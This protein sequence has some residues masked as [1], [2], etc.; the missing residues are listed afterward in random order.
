[1][2]AV[3]A[4]EQLSWEGLP[5]PHQ[6][7]GPPT[8]PEPARLLPWPTMWVGMPRPGRGGAPEAGSPQVHPTTLSS[9]ALGTSP[10]WNLSP[11]HLPGETEAR[12][13]PQPGPG[14]QP[15]GPHYRPSAPSLR[16]CLGSEPGR[17]Q[18]EGAALPTAG[19]EWRLHREEGEAASF[20]LGRAVEIKIKTQFLPP[21]FVAGAPQAS[22]PQAA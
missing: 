16:G 9:C 20:G 4:P 19:G 13:G 2:P 3:S 5:G 22:K 1:M 12:G 7:Q 10:H 14:R 15:A 11:R 8:G 18:G 17:Q 6:A 21:V